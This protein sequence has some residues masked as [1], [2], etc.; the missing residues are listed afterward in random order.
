M[1]GNF[2]ITEA[3]K[4]IVYGFCFGTIDKLI[5]LNQQQLDRILCLSTLVARKDDFSLIRNENDE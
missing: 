5:H 3:N 1:V 2:E 4:E